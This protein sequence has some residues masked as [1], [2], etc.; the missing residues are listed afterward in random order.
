MPAVDNDV[1]EVAVIHDN[2]T[3]GEQI[4]N[5]QFQLQSGGP[6]AE[7]DLLDDVQAIIQVIYTILATY[8]SIRNVLREVVVRNKTQGLLVG[9][10]DGGTYI[11]GL[12]VGDAVPQGVAP[13]V[14]YKTNIP[15]V[16]L[17]KYLPSVT[18]GSISVDGRVSTA[19]QAVMVTFGTV[20]AA[21]HVV[22][23]HVYEYGYDSPKV[24]GFVL[25]SLLV[26]A[27]VYAY[28]RRRKEGR[29]S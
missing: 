3:S 17:S 29:G 19:L 28:Q 9:T 6:V 23:G 22:G 20:L 4:N 24:V 16:V 26:V 12:H 10:T 18:E 15:R 25:P 7:A 5:Y 13:F 11:G 8:I 1:I 21:T 14:Y 2:T 27:N